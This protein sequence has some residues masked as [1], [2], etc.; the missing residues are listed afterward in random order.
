MSMNETNGYIT[1][2]HELSEE[3]KPAT[4]TFDEMVAQELIESGKP[5]ILIYD[6]HTGLQTTRL[7]TDD[8]IEE[9]ARHAPTFMPS[10][11]TKEID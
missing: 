1:I 5:T 4:P 7:M 6:A 9:C 11:Y 10:E 8:E 3:E 2:V